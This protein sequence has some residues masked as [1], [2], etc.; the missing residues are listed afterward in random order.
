VTTPDKGNPGSS[1]EPPT[2]EGSCLCAGVRFRV[3]GRLTPIQY[4]HC[5]RC[6]KV[7][8]GAFMAALATRSSNFAWTC[9]EDLV[10]TYTAP[11]RESP[12]A[13]RTMFCGRCGSTLPLFDPERP[14]VVIPAG[15]LDGDPGV[16]PFRHI[17]VAIKAPWHEITDALPRFDHHA[18]P[19]QRLPVK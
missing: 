2:V 13:Y 1:A 11:V 4:C 12:P 19:E 7:T 3:R 8:G 6:R 16:R 17:F 5:T 18:P 10:R 14:F 15:T 9:G